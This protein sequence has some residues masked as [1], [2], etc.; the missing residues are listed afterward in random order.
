MKPSFEEWMTGW[1]VSKKG[2]PYR[3]EPIPSTEVNQPPIIRSMGVKHNDTGYH[4][5]ITTPHSWRAEEFAWSIGIMTDLKPI[6]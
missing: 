2:T 3:R 1:G 4:F 5:W 6:Y